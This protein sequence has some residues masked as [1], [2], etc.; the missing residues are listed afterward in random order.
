M[1]TLIDSMATDGILASSEVARPEMEAVL[2]RL[3]AAERFDISNVAAYFAT[4]RDWMDWRLEDFPSPV[5]PFETLWMEFRKAAFDG[6]EPGGRFERVGLLI[7]TLDAQAL[8][9]DHVRL[10]PFVERGF[11]LERLRWVV[12]AM[13]FMQ[14][15]R[16][17]RPALV[18]QSEYGLDGDGAVMRGEGGSPMLFAGMTPDWREMSDRERFGRAAAI[19]RLALYPAMLAMS[20]SHCKNVRVVDGEPMPP[21]LARKYEQRHRRPPYSFK[22]LEI[23]PMREVLRREGGSEAVGLKRALHICRG[24]FATYSEDRPMFGRLAGRFWVPAHVRGRA[25][26]GVVEKEYRVKAGVVA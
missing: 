10:G 14:A 13:I 21:K 2:R 20:F 6:S 9:P 5:P 25:S 3:D 15:R 7:G 23:D 19:G 12:V 16:S 1:G 17:S 4:Q 8:G 18:A 26:E 11:D 24:H 22:V